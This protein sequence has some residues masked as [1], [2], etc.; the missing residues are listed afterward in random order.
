MATQT[1]EM[2]S[3]NGVLKPTHGE[4]PIPD[5]QRVRVAWEN[6]EAAQT[7]QKPR[8]AGLHAGMGWVSE[9]FDAELPDSFWMGEE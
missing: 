2:V 7:L 8:V 4:L 3:E 6:E 1:L 9:D 5:G